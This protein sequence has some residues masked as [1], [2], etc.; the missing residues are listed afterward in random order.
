MIEAE[1]EEAARR[2]RAGDAD[3]ALVY[4]YPAVPDMLPA[5]LELVHLI[6]DPYEVILPAGHA[7]AERRR[8]SLARPR[9]GALGGVHP[10]VRL[11]PDHR[12]AS[13]ARRASSPG[14]PSRPTRPA[15]PRRSWPPA[16]A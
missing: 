13:A 12:G 11:P 15:P 10:R 7:L 3:L 6:D 2:L 14:W 8:L 5:E 4:D 16:W 9:R 1:P